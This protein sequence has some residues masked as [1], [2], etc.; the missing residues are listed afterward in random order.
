MTE[1]E[2]GTEALI[3]GLTAGRHTP[4]DADAENA[5]LAGSL[6]SLSQLSSGLGLVDLLTRVASYAVRAIPGADGAGLT[7]LEPDRA[8]LIVKS[9]PFVRDIDDIQ[10][11]LGEGPCIS[12]AEEAATMRSGSLSGDPRWPHFGPRAGRLGVHSV[13]SLP[14]ITA[15]GVVG[16]MNVYAHAKDAF[17]ER[18]EQLGELFAIPAA[19]SVQ[20]A[21]I[22]AKTE[23]LAATLQAALTNRSVLDQAIGIVRSR[24]GSTA[25]EAF[26]RLREISQ[27]EHTKLAAVAETVVE[28]AARRARA[29]H[30]D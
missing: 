17:D 29:R 18:A 8:D 13:L 30:T 6:A 1:S 16:A 24:S 26:Q 12:A 20:N 2:S 19:I 14:L 7:M 25:E 5:D 27:H 15:E 10:Y 22:L 11:S 9:E 28:D 23:R 3:T 21:Q 4:D